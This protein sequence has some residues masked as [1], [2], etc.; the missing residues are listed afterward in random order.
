VP[1]R[2]VVTFEI[3]VPAAREDD[4]TCALWECGTLGVQVTEPSLGLVALVASFADS[5]DLDLR[6]RDA[7]GAIP[8]ASAR[9]VEV[10]EVDWVARFREDFRAFE[11]AGFT[12]VPEWEGRR[13][14]EDTIV[15]DPGRAFGTGTHQT[16]R[17]C[18]GFLVEEAGRR[19]LGRVI[20]V[21]AG[22]GLLAIAALRRGARMAVAA[23]LDPE[24]TA[25][26]ALHARLNGVPL[27]VVEA[28]G[29]RPFRAGRFDVLLA[30]LMAPLLIER[31]G[32]LHALC[33]PGGSLIL[34]GLLQED[35]E[36]VARAYAFGG[37]EPRLD[38]EWAALRVRLP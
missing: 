38:G 16:T 30:N 32:E 10:P 8:G 26:S 18:L 13:A 34:S 2:L 6:L 25:S 1:P 33:A 19:P 11:A 27:H 14:G 9:A 24:A 28:D 7:L 29:G 5:A 23:D 22:T 31:A 21:G 4:A 17:L 15:I 20:D 35:V 37:V 12:V 3:V 36:A